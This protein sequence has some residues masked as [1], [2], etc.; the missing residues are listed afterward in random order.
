MNFWEF[1]QFFDQE[2]LDA[3]GPWT[4]YVYDVPPIHYWDW[5][6]SGRTAQV[7]QHPNGSMLRCSTTSSPSMGMFSY[8]ANGVDW[9]DIVE[10]SFHQQDR[11]KAL[12]D[13]VQLDKS[14]VYRSVVQGWLLSLGMESTWTIRWSTLAGAEFFVRPTTDL[15]VSPPLFV[16]LRSTPSCDLSASLPPAL[17]DALLALE[18]LLLPQSVH[19]EISCVCPYQWRLSLPTD[20]DE[21]LRDLDAFQRFM[22]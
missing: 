14:E 5:A 4:D 6:T 12:Q 8:S 15:S 19:G 2:P 1:Y 16:F 21:R 9:H 11:L 22:A 13:R 18:D 7:C 17:K 10:L 3:W 20:S